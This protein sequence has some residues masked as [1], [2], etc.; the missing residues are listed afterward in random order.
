MK[1]NP[2]SCNVTWQATPLPECTW[3]MATPTVEKSTQTIGLYYPSATQMQ[4]ERERTLLLSRQTLADRHPPLTSISP[5]KGKTQ[6][7]TTIDALYCAMTDA[8]V[9]LC[10]QAT[11]GGSWTMCVLT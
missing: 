2:A 8:V 9:I 7:P 3:N 10:L 6:R 1:K 5:G 4:K 11:G